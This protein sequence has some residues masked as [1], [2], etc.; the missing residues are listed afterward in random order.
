VLCCAVLCCAV[1]CCAVLCCAVLCCASSIVMFL[2]G[3]SNNKL[4][5]F[6]INRRSVKEK[7]FKFIIKRKNGSQGCRQFLKSLR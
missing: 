3:G 7:Q 2:L 4:N 1:L 5:I 6:E